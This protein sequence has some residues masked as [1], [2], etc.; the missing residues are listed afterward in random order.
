MDPPPAPTPAGPGF[1]ARF[2]KVLQRR[3]LTAVNT[4]G[5]LLA[6]LA[7]GTLLGM[8]AIHGTS[9]AAA[10]LGAAL[11]TT[12]ACAFTADNIGSGAFAPQLC[13]EP[14]DAVYTWVNG[15]D[16]AWL[17]DMARWRAREAGL[18][19]TDDGDGG[20]EDA[21][22]GAGG[23]GSSST[24]P[25]ST[26]N[27]YR[28]NDELRYSLR[29]L[30]KYAPWLR[31]VVLV[32]NGQVPAW[33]DVTHPRLAV[34]THADIFPN[35][36][37]L[38]VFSSP[39]IEVHL[40]RIPGLS[41]RFVYFNDDVLL[42][43]DVWP[44]DFLTR[45]RGAKVYLSWEVPKCNP[46]CM[47]SWLGDGYCDTACNATRC[48]WDGGDCL[49]NATKSRGSSA[50]GSYRAGGGAATTTTSTASAAAVPEA[51]CAP[52]C[53]DTWLGDRMCDNKCA[54]PACGWDGGDCG[55]D[56]VWRDHPGGA[57]RLAAG[58]AAAAGV[59]G[60]S[61]SSGTAP[62]LSGPGRP[63]GATATAAASLLA[64]TLQRLLA[65][66]LP[67]NASSNTSGGAGRSFA[68]LCE[69][70]LTPTASAST[71]AALNSS[72]WRAVLETVSA[73]GGAEALAAA[74]L[75]DGP[76]D[77]TPGEAAFLNTSRLAE[78][79]TAHTAATLQAV[80]A[81]LAPPSSSAAAAAGS[82]VQPLAQRVCGLPAVAAA[83][84]G[85][86]PA[87]VTHIGSGGVNGTVTNASA[88]ATPA[89]PVARVTTS[90]CRVALQ[91]AAAAAVEAS[92]GDVPAAAGGT[93]QH[94]AAGDALATVVP[95]AGSFAYTGADYAVFP[96]PPQEG[97][98][99]AAVNVSGASG[100][101]N[102]T[103]APPTAAHHAGSP[104]LLRAGVLST[105]RGAAVR[106]PR[107]R[108]RQR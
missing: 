79:A 42:G 98:A 37:H 76:L 5:G 63:A 75:P 101:G 19:Y 47:E 40:H 34:V 13:G 100:G 88:A 89:A 26:A 77:V 103:V 28:D 50:Y 12:S 105:P 6:L 30:E 45:S 25:A 85:W 104:L 18:P 24:T 78:D 58:A 17:A 66:A 83:C 55:M 10:S 48:G 54:A 62:A 22:A 44:D 61:T 31:R 9:L 86:E 4:Q 73:S 64:A 16:P 93:Q 108:R 41:R 91:S 1:G 99:H 27:R 32:T 53:P 7:A 72:V 90:D 23:N 35:R 102:E 15:S 14:I 43:S 21:G 71:A 56:R 11:T 94:V 46:G 106:R 52:G 29:S 2:A 8:A 87:A 107:V 68:A 70:A 51:Q 80:L 49:G 96:P 82:A 33:L 74:P 81:A 57:P 60:G 69:S 3:A 67:V 84:D 92:A 95:G 65:A 36:S 20:G 38:P 39:A 97:A 59:G